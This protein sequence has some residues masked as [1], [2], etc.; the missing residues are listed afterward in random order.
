VR[1]NGKVAEFQDKYG[2]TKTIHKTRHGLKVKRDNLTPILQMNQA[3][4]GMFGE[5]IKKLREERGYTL[6]ELAHRIGIR[7]GHPKNR[8]WEIENT[9]RREGVRMGT[10]YAIAMA[11][12]VEVS[13][14][15]PSVSE[16]AEE[17]GVRQVPIPTLSQ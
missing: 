4:A 17:A 13:E 8:M 2:D 15:L 10:L 5:R 14:L 12:E 6:E 7:S 3:I 16:V 1:T 9:V 11:L